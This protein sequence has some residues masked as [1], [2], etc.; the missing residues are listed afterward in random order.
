M[1][2]RSYVTDHGNRVAIDV[3]SDDRRK[4]ERF[5]LSGSI[6]DVRG[7]HIGTFEHKSDGTSTFRSNKDGAKPSGMTG[8]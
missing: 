4:T 6:A 5:D 7:K 2:K 1:G 8:R 3:T